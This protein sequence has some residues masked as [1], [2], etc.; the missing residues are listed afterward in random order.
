MS[1]NQFS[2]LKSMDH[3]TN[4]NRTFCPCCNIT[5]TKNYSKKHIG[6]QIH[7]SNIIKFIEYLIDVKLNYIPKPDDHDMEIINTKYK[8]FIQM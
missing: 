4:K 8:K 7:K 6:T 5:L 1:E 2:N 3:V